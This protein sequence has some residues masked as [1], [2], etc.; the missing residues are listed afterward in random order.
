MSPV[1]VQLLAIVLIVVAVVFAM[2][3]A[4]TNLQE[5]AGIMEVSS[6]L[7]SA[8]QLASAHF[9][10]TVPSREVENSLQELTTELANSGIEEV[11]EAMDP[12]SAGITEIGTLKR[13]NSDIESE[14]MELSEHSISQS[15]G[16]IQQVVAR[17][18]DPDERDQ[19]TNL[20]RQ[21]IVGANV[22]TSSNWAIR[23]LFYRMSYDPGAKDELR[24]FMDQALENVARDVE[25]L[26]GTPF[27]QMPIEAQQSNLQLS[28]LIDEYIGNLESIAASREEIQS[29]LRGLNASLAEAEIALQANTA[30]AVQQ[31]FLVIGIVTVAAALAVAL[32]SALLGLRI[33]QSI[34][35]TANMLREIA[36]GE[37]DLT[38][39]VETKT[40]DEIG[41]LGRYFNLTMDTIEGMIASIRREAAT[42]R[43]IGTD[44]T[45]RMEGAASAVN[46]ISANIS[47]VKSQTVSQSAGVTETHATI[48]EIVQTIERLNSHIESQSVQVVESSSA[49]EEM[50]ASIGS[51]SQ[52]LEKNAHATGELLSASELGSGGMEKVTT[53]VTAIANES[54]GLLEASA[55]IESIAS[56][57]NLLAMN[58]AIEAAHAGEAGKGFSV[59]AD[60]I[61]KLAENAGSQAKSIS[62]VLGELKGLIDQ[63]ADSSKDAGEQFDRVVTLT[64]QV[65]E[66]ET[67]IKNAM[68]EQTAGSTQVLQAMK[69]IND[70]TVEVKDG[71]AA[72]LSG[73]KEVLNEMDRLAAVTEEITS[74][75][76]EMTVG[77]QKINEAV[78]HAND[79]GKT[80]EQSI[81]TLSEEI[82][83][84]RTAE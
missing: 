5:T 6:Q 8:R 38:A 52:I 39:R 26:A 7:D 3:T 69:E 32:L 37:G 48:S 21:V 55:V 77:T 70:I 53:H 25:M 13:R 34:G 49:V 12:T 2:R 29:T 17:L 73:S 30:E 23:T 65:N 67:V 45:E 14:I 74:S 9:H 66:Q 61:R 20:E 76:N 75:M 33:S 64:R 35:G 62:T 46:E 36:A 16:Y 51:V 11:E 57:T 4:R 27:E 83:R 78:N 71:S 58:A 63:V 42:L 56:Q 54:E 82:G 84:F 31:S 60:E 24:D 72:M 40:N 19:V 80:N 22:N 43:Q 47:G 18:L 81:V 79:L 68:E 50:V 44:L 10:A 1:A 59:V 15:N 41:D 28:A